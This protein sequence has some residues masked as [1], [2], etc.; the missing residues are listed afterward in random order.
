MTAPFSGTGKNFENGPSDRWNHCVICA[1]GQVDYPV[2]NYLY[3]YS[4]TEIVGPI[5]QG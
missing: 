2:D 5:W 4:E 3:M 1:M